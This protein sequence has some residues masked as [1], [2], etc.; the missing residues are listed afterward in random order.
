MDLQLNGKVA[1]VTGSTAGIGFGIAQKLA[2]EKA[3][4]IVNGRTKESVEKAVTEI[5]QKTGRENIS[6]I[7]ADFSRSADVEELIRR[8]PD[9]DIL[10][11]NV[12]IF[13]EVDFVEIDDEKWF[14][15]FE[16]NV[17]SGV[18]LARHYFPRMLRKDE[19]RIIFISSESA[20]NIPV[21]MIHYGMTKTAQLAVSRGLA[22]LAR[23]TR[24]TVN[25]ILPGPT[26]SRGVDEMLAAQS[27]KTGKSLR[28]VED[29]FFQDAR[30]TSLIQRF[31]NVDEVAAMA[32]YVSSPVSSAT[33]GAAL[34]VDGGVVNSIH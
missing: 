6:G 10:I 8:I 24:V 11:N 5:K 18:R 17:M 33:S 27:K 9:V 13:E 14:E 16:V 4:V 15:I 2:G 26:R 29:D 19:G 3:D 12:G 34:R 7:P 20:L 22:R 28:E 32:V 23:G 30:P 21:E 1:L 31:A 25:A